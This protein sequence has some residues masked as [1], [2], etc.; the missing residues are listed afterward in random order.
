VGFFENWISNHSCNFD[1]TSRFLVI[2][3]T[4]V[5]ELVSIELDR[6]AS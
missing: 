2:L 6:V 3:Y 5:N 1:G 4:S